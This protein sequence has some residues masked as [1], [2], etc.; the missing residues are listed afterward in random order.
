MLAIALR[1]A[2]AAAVS[3]GAGA[4][5]AAGATGASVI[6]TEEPWMMRPRWVR[7]AVSKG[8]P[9]AKAGVA[10]AE[11]EV[12]VE[13]RGGA[14]SSAMTAPAAGEGDRS[15][16]HAILMCFRSAFWRDHA[17]APCVPVVRP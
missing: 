16:L 3:A 1:V 4:T 7:T 2:V 14:T 15:V 10:E 13:E 5:T 12:A 6:R 9:A 8:A 11:G 17:A